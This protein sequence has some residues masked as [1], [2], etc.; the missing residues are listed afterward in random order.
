M[1]DVSATLLQLSGCTR[2]LSSVS[3]CCQLDHGCSEPRDYYSI[4]TSNLSKFVE[5]S[6]H[7]SSLQ[8]K[9]ACVV[10]IHQLEL[11][12]RHPALRRL[13]VTCSKYAKAEAR[14]LAGA[15]RGMTI[16]VQVWKGRGSDGWP[17][18]AEVHEGT[19]ALL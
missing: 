17:K 14:Q 15:A 1:I 4:T 7:L 2:R 12:S 5:S 13:V 11:L 3:L 18:F 10:A 6:P 16:D 19:A 9:G 8:I